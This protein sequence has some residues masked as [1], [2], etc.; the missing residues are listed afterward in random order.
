MRRI[1]LLPL[2]L[3]SSCA[4]TPRLQPGAETVK[5][6]TDTSSREIAGHEMIGTLK[7]DKGKGGSG[8]TKFNLE[9]C[10]TELVNRAYEV[11]ASMLVIDKADLGASNC[12]TRV[13]VTGT[14]YK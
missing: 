3:V 11:G 7:C 4:T 8:T 1:I 13:I 5:L 14:A 6:I 2:L 9:A 12:T 10:H